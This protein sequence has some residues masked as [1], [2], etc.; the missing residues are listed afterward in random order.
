MEKYGHGTKLWPTERVSVWDNE[1]ILVMDSGE[2]CIHECHWNTHLK[3]AQN[4]KFYV[5]YI[6]LL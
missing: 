6:I 1:Y 2:G 5:M 4:G 3:N